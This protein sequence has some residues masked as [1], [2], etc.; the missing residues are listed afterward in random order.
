VAFCLTD[1]A[2]TIQHHEGFCIVPSDKSGRDSAQELTELASTL[3]AVLN[4]N[5]TKPAD[6]EI[7]PESPIKARG[8]GQ[9]ALPSGHPLSSSNGGAGADDDVA[10]PIRAIKHAPQ[11]PP[12]GTVR[13]PSAGHSSKAGTAAS[14]KTSQGDVG[15]HDA[16]AHDELG[17]F[18]NQGAE[19][20]NEQDL[21]RAAFAEFQSGVATQAVWVQGGSSGGACRRV[22][23]SAVYS[24]I[25]GN[26]VRTG[27]LDALTIGGQRV[28]GYCTAA[29]HP[30]H[31]AQGSS[32][33][34]R[35]AC[36]ELVPLTCGN[37]V[38]TQ[39]A[40]GQQLQV[41]PVLHFTAAGD[42]GS[43]EGKTFSLGIN[44]VL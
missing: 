39:Q 13:A 31:R 22:A 44:Y 12:S 40:G 14:G 42:H 28:F 11:Q 34:S 24:V 9:L 33:V 26:A 38:W 8:G 32:T 15:A 23:S 35:A 21:D 16:G 20:I 7:M 27:G 6:A 36:S 19:R 18:D 43:V 5:C 1:A 17:L 30:L 37:V 4:K 2:G 25:I 10:G 41:L 3:T 29:S